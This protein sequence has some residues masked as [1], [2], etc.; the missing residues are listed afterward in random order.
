MFDVLRQKKSPSTSAWIE[1]GWCYSRGRGN[2][3]N[4]TGALRAEVE[5]G[6]CALRMLKLPALKNCHEKVRR[7]ISSSL[8]NLKNM[9]WKLRLNSLDCVRLWANVGLFIFFAACDCVI[10]FCFSKSRRS[11]SSLLRL[12]WAIG[13]IIAA[14]TSWSREMFQELLL[15]TSIFLPTKKRCAIFLSLK[16]D[17]I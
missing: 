13:V 10:H 4:D 8:D 17:Q 15:Q 16:N 1:R 6:N 14:I 9:T 3:I 7:E 11:V 12:D 2:L 5:T